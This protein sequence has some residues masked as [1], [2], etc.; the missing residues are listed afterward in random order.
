MLVSYRIEFMSLLFKGEAYGS[1]SQ[2]LIL[3]TAKGIKGFFAKLSSGRTGDFITICLQ[4]WKFAHLY[5]LDN[6]FLKLR[7]QC[8]R[9]NCVF[10]FSLKVAPK[11]FM[12]C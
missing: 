8:Y 2:A 11:V 3:Y 9:N 5:H 1:V 4:H 10:F 12:C 7:V 6:Y